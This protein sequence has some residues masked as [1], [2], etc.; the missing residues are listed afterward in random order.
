M[1]CSLAYT[2]P[3]THSR[4]ILYPWNSFLS[5]KLTL[6][7]FIL[8]IYWR[9]KNFSQAH[10]TQHNTLSYFFLLFFFSFTPFPFISLPFTFLLYAGG[11][12]FYWRIFLPPPP[13]GTPSRRMKSSSGSTTWSTRW[14][15]SISSS[16]LRT[17]A[18]SAS[19]S[20]KFIISC[21]EKYRAAVWAV[22]VLLGLS[23]VFLG[24]GVPILLTEGM[25]VKLPR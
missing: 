6:S 3:L 21:R 9:G 13:S 19:K 5:A 12:P 4:F 10:S 23:R 7:S 25:A 14:R 11:F 22:A 18:S 24:R 16:S 17:A 20:S 1:L 8:L 2:V 15:E